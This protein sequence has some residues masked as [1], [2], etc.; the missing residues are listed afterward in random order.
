[1]RADS[2]VKGAT[3]AAPAFLASQPERRRIKAT[4]LTPHR[5]GP[6]IVR[7][8][9]NA[10]GVLSRA[11]AEMMLQYLLTAGSITDWESGDLND[12]GVLTAADLSLLKAM[13]A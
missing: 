2:S 7:G 5:I 9:V 4:V 8:D 3:N 11:D 6:Y 13:I 1:M 10:D 12:D